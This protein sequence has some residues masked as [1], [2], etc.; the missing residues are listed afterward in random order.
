MS[1]RQRAVDLLDAITASPDAMYALTQVGVTV[2]VERVENAIL[3]ARATLSDRHG[4][5]LDVDSDRAWADIEPEALAFLD[6]DY[7]EVFAVTTEP[8]AA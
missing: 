5:T 4:V 2:T 6:L 8:V 7:D 1:L 3:S